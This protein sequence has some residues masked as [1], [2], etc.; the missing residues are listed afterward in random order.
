MLRSGRPLPC[1]SAFADVSTLTAVLLVAARAAQ[2]ILLPQSSAATF[3]I[4][5]LSLWSC[6]PALLVL[7]AGWGGWSSIVRPISAAHG[8][9]LRAVLYEVAAVLGCTAVLFALLLED[10]RSFGVAVCAGF[11][12]YVFPAAPHKGLS[13]YLGLG[14]GTIGALT[15]YWG[16]KHTGLWNWVSPAF[17]EA[18]RATRTVW[19]V[20]GVPRGF[21]WGPPPFR[22]PSYR[23]RCT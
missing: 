6:A 17:H 9:T 3:D 13:L 10:M 8:S 7:G 15:E 23:P 16:C 4:D 20:G 1:S 22:P 19:M 2:F 14:A 12:F 11:L 18:D 5:A 21:P